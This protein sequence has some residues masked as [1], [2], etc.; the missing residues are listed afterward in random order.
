[1]S[2]GKQNP[3]FSGSATQMGTGRQELGTIPS[4]ANQK[5]WRYTM[6]CDKDDNR[7]LRLDGGKGRSFAFRFD[8]GLSKEDVAA[9]RPVTV[10]RLSDSV[11]HDPDGS[12][13]V[14]KGS[15]QVHKS[16][17]TLI[18]ATFHDGKG[19]S[20]LMF[21]DSGKGWTVKPGKKSTLADMTARFVS[22]MGKQASVCCP[23][24]GVTPGKY[25]IQGDA[26]SCGDCGKTSDME[27]WEKTA[28]N[29]VHYSRDKHPELRPLSYDELVKDRTSGRWEDK[30]EMAE[31][32]VQDRKKFESELHQRLAR[33]GVEVDPNR[34]FL[35]ATIDGREKFY[36]GLEG[37]KHT[38]PLSDDVVAKSFFDVAGD[39]KS[40]TVMGP[41][42]LAAAIRRWDLAESSGK[43][44][45][46]EYMGM[47]IRPR[48]EVITPSE[49][50][51]T[52]IKEEIGR[53]HV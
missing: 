31:Q 40:R 35:Y 29:L 44:Q 17:P 10:T 13:V 11:S 42:G 50:K 20:T 1:M 18:H 53:A 28:L 21:E 22:V 16:S 12:E 47:T 37:Y 19:G 8:S 43:L 25:K 9:G 34:S 7:I 45:P 27:K 33:K 14:T 3:T 24:C 52:E 46:Q 5:N 30:P 15:V 32:Y 39:G 2:N 23:C 49:L 26:I 38:V 4:A 6:V 48:I 36:D 41:R 51:P